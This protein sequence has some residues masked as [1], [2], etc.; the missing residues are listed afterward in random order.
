MMF[1]DITGKTIREK[2]VSALSN[3]S[4]WIGKERLT[5]QYRVGVFIESTALLK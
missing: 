5:A 4:G 1:W 3:N 2:K